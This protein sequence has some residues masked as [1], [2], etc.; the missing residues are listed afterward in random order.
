VLEQTIIDVENAKGS[1][2]A[3]MRETLLEKALKSI[4][5]YEQP[6][7]YVDPTRDLV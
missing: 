6:E 5:E 1:K 4:I 3:K 2:S 7:F